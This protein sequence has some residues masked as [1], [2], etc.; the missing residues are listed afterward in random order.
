MRDGGL[1]TLRRRER[2]SWILLVGTSEEEE[3][4]EERRK[5]SRCGVGEGVGT[6]P[7]MLESAV[8]RSTRRRTSWTRI[9]LQICKTVGCFSLL[10]LLL[11]LQ[12]SARRKRAEEVEEQS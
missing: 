6:L 2:S 5:G 12:R 3:E 10:L 7:R 1:G 8:E 4:E 11:L 9:P